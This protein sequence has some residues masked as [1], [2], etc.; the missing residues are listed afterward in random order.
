MIIHVYSDPG[1][2]WARVKRSLINE[3]G[4]AD[5][6]SCFS[7]QRGKFVYLEEDVDAGVFVS[8]LKSAGIEY[9]V[10]EH[11]TNNES[12]IRSY[13]SFCT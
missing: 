13:E 12:A 11:T 4:I 7:Y 2:G 6:I 1:H 3:L 5:K 9:S 10:K 8:A